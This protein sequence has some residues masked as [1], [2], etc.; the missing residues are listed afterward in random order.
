MP[1]NRRHAATTA[2]LLA[3]RASTQRLERILT[4]T[5]GVLALIA[6]FFMLVL[7]LR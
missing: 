3:R 6:V 1:K 5:L 7:G 4:V 2:P